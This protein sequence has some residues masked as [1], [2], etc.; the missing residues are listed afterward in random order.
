M[1]RYKDAVAR[2][3][4]GIQQ[5]FDYGDRTDGQPEYQGHASIDR[6]D[7]D[8]RWVIHKYTYNVEG[9]P[10][11]IQSKEGAWSGRVALFS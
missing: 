8:V 6:D 4:P 9:F 7:D 10:T 1:P 3:I 2:D 5:K 11:V